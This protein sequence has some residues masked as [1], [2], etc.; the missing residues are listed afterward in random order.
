M[1]LPVVDYLQ[2]AVLVASS[3]ADHCLPEADFAVA[4]QTAALPP[5][6][7]LLPG[8]DCEIPEAS[9]LCWAAWFLVQR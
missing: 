3:T 7:L 8:A 4:D 1:N 6:A 2:A 9:Y 5:P